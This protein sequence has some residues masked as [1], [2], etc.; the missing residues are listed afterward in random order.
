MGYDIAEISRSGSHGLLSSMM[1]FQANCGKLPEGMD[2][3]IYIYT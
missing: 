2:L 1:M 3:G